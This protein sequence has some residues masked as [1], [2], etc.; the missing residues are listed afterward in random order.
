MRNRSVFLTQG[1]VSLALRPLLKYNCYYSPAIETLTYTDAQK[2]VELEFDGKIEKFSIYD[3]L[4]MMSKED[5]EA[6]LPAELR[7]KNEKREEEDLSNLVLD[8]LG[9][10][11]NKVKR[12]RDRNDKILKNES[13]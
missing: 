1:R 6:S 7:E 4:T 11:V 10:G 12:S 5:Y 9:D 13:Y 8:V 3:A 2:I